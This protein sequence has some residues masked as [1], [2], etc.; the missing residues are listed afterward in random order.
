MEH[1][2]DCNERSGPDQ[3]HAS[4]LVEFDMKYQRMALRFHYSELFLQIP[5][6]GEDLQRDVGCSHVAKT[7]R[8]V[9][10]YLPH[11]RLNAFSAFDAATA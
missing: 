9:D 4:L 11:P 2:Q 3:S 6:I 1:I 5:K 10:N 8:G 7:L